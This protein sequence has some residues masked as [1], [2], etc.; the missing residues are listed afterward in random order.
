MTLGEEQRISDAKKYGTEL[1]HQTSGDIAEIILRSPP[2]KQMKP[3]TEGLAGG[4]IY[5]ATTP[6]LTGH[7]A[8]AHGVILRAYVRLGKIKTLEAE[9]DTRMTLDKLK[10]QGFDSVCIARKVSSGQEY[11]VYDPDQVLF[12]ERA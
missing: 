2:G 5:F 7:K 12:I 11:V 8:H 10:R 3:G 1:Y 4:G 6:E 9:G